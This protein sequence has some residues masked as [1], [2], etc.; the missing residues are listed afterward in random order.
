MSE[1]F[2]SIVM[3][4]FN[5]EKNL[6]RAIFSVF[7]QTFYNFELILVD[8]C[9]TD[10]SLEICREL[11]RKDQRVK[12]IALEKNSGAAAARNAALDVIG[13][14]YVTF[15]DADDWIEDNVLARAAAALKSDGS[16]DC[17]KYGCSED[18]IDRDGQVSY[19]K[20]CR[21]ADETLSERGAIARKI[22]ELETV[23]LFGY[24]WNGFYRAALIKKYSVRFDVAR[25][26]NEDFFFNAEFFRRVKVFRTVDCAGYHYEKR[27]VGSL[28]SEAKNFSYEI[29]RQKIAALLGMFDDVV[30]SDVAEKIFWMYARF[31][32]AALVDG[33]KLS[34]IR[35][36]PIFKKFISVEFRDINL[37]QRLLTGLLRKKIFSPILFAAVKLIGGIKK[38]APTL[39]ARLKK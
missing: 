11:E 28:S 38:S 2:V 30:P 7:N 16:I 21:V 9:S 10:R 39:F 36:D 26:V 18:Y 6:R 13:G 22:V 20:L 8:D 5:A 1:P 19:R 35:A 34:V 15:V 12:V 29:N 24:V 31:C 33:E 32:Y 14:R 23:P 4:V 25:R 37:K 27:G 3:P 17:L